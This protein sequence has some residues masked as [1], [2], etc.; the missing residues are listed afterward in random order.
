M[1]EGEKTGPLVINAK[2]NEVSLNNHIVDTT[3]DSSEEGQNIVDN[4]LKT[5]SEKDEIMIVGYDCSK[6]IF[7]S[8]R[9][10]PSPWL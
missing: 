8:S 6:C 2:A 1:P 7:R 5:L 4:I 9:Y 3:F 10:V